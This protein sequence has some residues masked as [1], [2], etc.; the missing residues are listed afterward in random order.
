MWAR[1]PCDSEMMQYGTLYG[2]GY[3]SNMLYTK[4]TLGAEFGPHHSLALYSGPMWAAVQDHQGHADG[5]GDS[6]YKGLLSSIRYDFPLLLRP[7]EA[8]GIKRFEVFGHVVAEVF[9]P[10][11]YYDSSR[12][13]YFIR[14]EFTV[15]F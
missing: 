11:D 15:R 8:Q 5:S 14:W 12:P 2:L 1:A 13:A 7:K 4:L 3:W 6:L 10:G 9:N